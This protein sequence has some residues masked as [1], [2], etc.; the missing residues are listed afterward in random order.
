MSAKVA[1]CLVDPEK[2]VVWPPPTPLKKKR[3]DHWEYYTKKKLKKITIWL[4]VG[5]QTKRWLIKF[6]KIQKHKYVK[7]VLWKAQNGCLLA[8][9]SLPNNKSKSQKKGN[10]AVIG[11][12]SVKKKCTS[13]YPKCQHKHKKGGWLPPLQAIGHRRSL[14]EKQGRR[15]AN[16]KWRPPPSCSGSAMTRGTAM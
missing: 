7:K 2:I 11:R 12:Q 15:R 6:D 9:I 1:V 5:H 14:R 4:G 8:A 16:A 3:S 10:A 13:I